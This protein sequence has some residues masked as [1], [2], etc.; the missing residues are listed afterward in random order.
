M[1]NSD[2]PKGGF[3]GPYSKE[4]PT[5][6]VGRFFKALR[7]LAIIIAGWSFC[8]VALTAVSV[9]A[10]ITFRIGSAAYFHRVAGFCARVLLRLHGIRVE[11]V[12]PELFTGR[13]ARL[14]FMNHGSQLDLFI[15][16][17]IL[18]P[19]GTTMAKKQVYYIPFINFIFFAFAI[20]TIDRTNL[21]KAIGAL[22]R[23][24][25]LI[26][27][28]EATVCISPEGTRSRTGKLGPFKKGPFHLAAHLDVP[29]VLAVI[30][31]ANECLPMGRLVSKPGVV[32]VEMVAEIPG[33]RFTAD[34]VEEMRDEVRAIYLRELGETEPDSEAAA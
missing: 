15:M 22:N 31:G 32:R 24:G 16:S 26:I 1:N 11:L 2:V 6:V 14:V 7:G 13:K 27:T 23:V 33:E 20:P 30:K 9:F 18:P 12:N 28:R 34:N 29:I 4:E 25:K 8:A 19:Y 5:S 10:L 21:K 17:A 3:Y